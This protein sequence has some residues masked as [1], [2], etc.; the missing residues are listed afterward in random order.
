MHT[1]SSTL[2][3]YRIAIQANRAL[4]VMLEP[5]STIES[6]NGTIW[7]TQEADT[8]DYC[9]PAGVTFCADRS[10]RA[11]LSAIDAPVL[12][13]LREPERTACTRPR[14]TIDSIERLT[15]AARAAQSAYVAHA[16]VRLLR[17]IA[18]AVRAIAHSVTRRRTKIQSAC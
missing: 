15:S 13:V 4:S 16:L 3:D 5:G 11:V 9:I 1:T 18:L 2:R 7:L 14:F 8:R 10:G 6:M 17:G 12:A